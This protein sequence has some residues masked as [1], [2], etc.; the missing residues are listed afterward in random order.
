MHRK[1]GKL[2]IALCIV[3]AMVLITIG[4]LWDRKAS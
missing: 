2:R 3:L 4:R 1:P